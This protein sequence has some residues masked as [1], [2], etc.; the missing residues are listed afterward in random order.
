MMIAYYPTSLK[1]HHTNGLF[2]YALADPRDVARDTA[3]TQAGKKL[4]RLA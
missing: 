1:R 3:I 2:Y 4:V